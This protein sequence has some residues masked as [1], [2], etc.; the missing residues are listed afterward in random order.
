MPPTGAFPSVVAPSSSLFTGLVGPIV[1]GFFEVDQLSLAILLA[2]A[3]LAALLTLCAPATGSF[4][5]HLVMLLFFFIGAFGIV[6]ARHVLVFFGAWEF[7][8][9]FAWGLARLAGEAES[10]EA[11][12]VPFQAA[13]PLGS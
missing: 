13:G 7:A 12:G 11:G 8:S 1:P 2:L 6:T 5:R 3:A 4:F 9:L 10:L